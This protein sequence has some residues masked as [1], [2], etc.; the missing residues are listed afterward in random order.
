M[1][2][3]PERAAQVAE[4]S[5]SAVA[6]VSAH[7]QH[8]PSSISEMLHVRD[9]H[10]AVIFEQCSMPFLLMSASKSFKRYHSRSDAS[11]MERPGSSA[12]MGSS[13]QSMSSIK[14]LLSLRLHPTP[15]QPRVDLASWIDNTVPSL[16]SP[17]AFSF[18]NE[19][20]EELT[21]LSPIQSMSPQAVQHS[22]NLPPAQYKET[23]IYSDYGSSMRARACFNDEDSCY[24][25]SPKCSISDEMRIVSDYK[26]AGTPNSYG[27]YSFVDYRDNFDR[28]KF[29]SIET[30]STSIASSRMSELSAR[31]HGKYRHL[32]EAF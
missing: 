20:E 24:H 26:D 6:Q 3:A 16:Q 5:S 7:R 4:T 31:Y 2:F 30:S 1:H 9:S 18:E 27:Q 17:I 15:P 12:S 28:N 8:L 25:C 29:G 22:H 19:L 10:M 21:E 14:Q 23:P 32:Y 13:R 11:T